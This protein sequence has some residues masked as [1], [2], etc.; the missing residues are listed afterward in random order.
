MPARTPRQTLRPTSPHS[1][2]SAPDASSAAC[3]LSKPFG[4]LVALPILFNNSGSSSSISFLPDMLTAFFSNDNSSDGGILE[5]AYVTTRSSLDA[6]FS[7]PTAGPEHQRGGHGLWCQLASADS[8][9]ADRVF[10]QRVHGRLH[11]MGRHARE[12]RKRLHADRAG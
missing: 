11:G 6:S 12:H 7:S 10:R 1:D 3:D 8:R 2:V 4:T 9:W 5:Q